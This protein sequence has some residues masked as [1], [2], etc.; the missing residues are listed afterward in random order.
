MM[1]PR[2]TSLHVSANETINWRNKTGFRLFHC[3]YLMSIFGRKFGISSIY[4]FD[5]IWLKAYTVLRVLVNATLVYG[6]ITSS[7]LAHRKKFSDFAVRKFS[8]LESIATPF[9]SWWRRMA[10]GDTM[11]C[12]GFLSCWPGWWKE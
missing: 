12:P 5:C 4:P 1:L 3:V 11:C 9:V 8:T 10:Y 7:H 6:K 2:R